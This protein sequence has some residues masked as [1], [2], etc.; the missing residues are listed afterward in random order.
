MIFTKSRLLGIAALSQHWEGED[1]GKAKVMAH[2][3]EEEMQ[4]NITIKKR[5]HNQVYIHAD[6]KLQVTSWIY[7]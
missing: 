4:G 6:Q 5:D 2:R 3:G 7:E 1:K